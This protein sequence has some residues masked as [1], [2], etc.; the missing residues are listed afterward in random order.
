VKLSER[1]HPT[2]PRC[3]RLTVQREACYLQFSDAQP[4]HSNEI[5]TTARGELMIADYDAD[6][7]IVGIELVASHKPCQER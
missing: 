4:H 6:A 7:R 1:H 2:L 3:H 5:V